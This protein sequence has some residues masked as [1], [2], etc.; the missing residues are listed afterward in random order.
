M[1]Q[2]PARR[3]SAHLERFPAAEITLPWQSPDGRPRTFALVFTG[4]K[5]G[6]CNRAAFNSKIWVP[7][8]RRAGHNLGWNL[9]PPSKR[10]TSAFM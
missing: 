8:R 2:S 3:D 4:D 6:P 9:I 7:A 10:T 1:V 5:G